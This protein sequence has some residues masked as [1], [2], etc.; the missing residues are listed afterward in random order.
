MSSMHSPGRQ[1]IHV[2]NNPY[3]T[4]GYLS[5][6]YLSKKLEF[7]YTLLVQINLNFVILDD[8]ICIYKVASELVSSTHVP[9]N[10]HI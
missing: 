10:F 5:C 4:E 6:G 8:P 3:A 1:L 9:Y 7:F 2:F